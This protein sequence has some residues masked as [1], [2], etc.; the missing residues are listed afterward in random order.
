MPFAG[1]RLVDTAML[2][3]PVPFYMLGRGAVTQETNPFFR[4]WEQLSYAGTEAKRCGVDGGVLSAN[5]HFGASASV[6][7][8][9]DFVMSHMMAV[10]TAG[11]DSTGT[12]GAD[13]A[14]T[15]D[16]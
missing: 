8:I 7:A 9:D 6:L 15:E 10:G 5:E 2:L 16:F 3:P 14:A 4:C 11:T 1:T 13:A 12:A